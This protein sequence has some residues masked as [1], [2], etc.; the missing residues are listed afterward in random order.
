M[1]LLDDIS[2]SFPVGSARGPL[3]FVARGQSNPLGVWRLVT[4]HGAYAVKLRT[5]QP[6]ARAVSIERH[7]WRAG[8][9]MPEPLETHAGEAYLPVDAAVAPGAPAGSGPVF[10]RVHAWVNGRALDWG[11]VDAGLSAQVGA[12]MAA[13]HHATVPAALLQEPRWQASGEAG[14]QALQAQ[15]QTRGLI[16]ADALAVAVPRL[17]AH[18]AFA[19]MYDEPAP[20]VPS[21]RD[22]HPPNVLLRPD[23]GLALVDWDAAGPAVASA[24]VT[25]FAEV[26][27]TPEHGPAD[28]QSHQAFIDGYCTAGGLYIPRGAADRVPAS[29]ALLHWIQVNLTR[30]LDPHALGD[31]ELSLAL[32]QG[33]REP[34]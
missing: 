30:D 26:W 9:P 15:A 2:T 17:L 13:V 14:W 7:A 23:G 27:S 11:T 3:V 6:D 22:Y 28:P 18:E 12:L 31:P 19:A 16:W 8:V 20:C 32:L 34:G 25:K 1:S 24:D 4:A 5:V 10:V 29:I 33:L 21:Q